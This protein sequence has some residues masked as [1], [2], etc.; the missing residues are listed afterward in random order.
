M[1]TQAL[2]GDPTISRKSLTEANTLAKVSR[3]VHL[4]PVHNVRLG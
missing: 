4:I 3:T 2:V 1:V